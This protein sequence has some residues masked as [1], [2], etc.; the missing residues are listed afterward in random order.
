MISKCAGYLPEN[1]RRCVVPVETDG[2][3]PNHGA[4][5]P[6]TRW[7]LVARALSGESAAPGNSRTAMEE[8]CEAYWYPLYAFARKTGL[9][10]TDAEDLVQGFFLRVL[11]DGALATADRSRGRLR[12][13][14]LKVFRNQMT[15]EVRRRGAKKRGGGH[16]H[17]SLDATWAEDRYGLEPEADDSLDP[18]RAHDR[19]WAL[20]M[21]E[22]VL[23]ALE[24]E[25]SSACGGNEWALLSPFLKFSTGGKASYNAAAGE[26]GWTVNATR[27]KVFR[28]RRRFRA[29]LIEAV[30][31]T[32]EEATPDAI[33]AEIRE[34]ME[35]LV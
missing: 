15:D 5:F 17:L 25:Q 28:L 21:L 32:L 30:A 29:L 4:A 10:S 34:L 35:A 24:T 14:F 7:S 3:V 22:R 23:T 20:L 8:I 19:R 26:L 12:T 2:A 33:E 27:V 31:D 18:R 16:P 9:R 13:Y 6:Q 11:E 1:G